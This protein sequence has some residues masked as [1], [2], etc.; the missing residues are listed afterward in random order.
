MTSWVGKD[1]EIGIPADSLFIA[2]FTLAGYALICGA[3]HVILKGMN[4]EGEKPTVED[5]LF[6]KLLKTPQ[7]FYRA[8]FL[9]MAAVVGYLQIHDTCDLPDDGG[10]HC[11]NWHLIYWYSLLFVVTANISNRPYEFYLGEG[12]S[13]TDLL[14]FYLRNRPLPT[15]EDLENRVRDKYLNESDNDEST[16]GI[17]FWTLMPSAFITWIFAKS[18]RNSAV[19]GARFGVLGGLAYDSWYLSFFLLCHSMLC[20]AHPL[21]LQVAPHCDIQELRGCGGDL[22]PA[23][24]ALPALQ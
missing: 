13:L 9:V 10:R 2:I 7:F 3:V 18:I 19:L 15:A 24:R 22:L 21:Q 6:R 1:G 20:A 11:D 5:S 8:I 12:V 14:K 17:G 23:L 4:P 16:A